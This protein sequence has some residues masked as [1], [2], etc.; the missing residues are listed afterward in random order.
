MAV[1]YEAIKRGHPN[2]VGVA[3]ERAQEAAPAS[4]TIDLATFRERPP[5]AHHGGNSMTTVTP[6][7]V[8]TKAA[9]EQFAASTSL[10]TVT[11]FTCKMTYAIPTSLYKSAKEWTAT[12]TTAGAGSSAARSVTRG[13][14]PASRPRPSG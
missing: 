2:S 3:L 10:T 11:C 12:A 7:H 14:T 1:S 6:E 13:G 5:K 9:G 8:H 4:G